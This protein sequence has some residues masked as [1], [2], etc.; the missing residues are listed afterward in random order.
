MFA[1]DD[2]DSTTKSTATIILPFRNLLRTTTSIQPSCWVPVSRYKSME[3]IVCGT[4]KWTL[5]KRRK[6]KIGNLTPYTYDIQKKNKP[7]SL[8]NNK[9]TNNCWFGQNLRP[10][11]STNQRK[12]EI[13]RCIYLIPLLPPIYLELF[14]RSKPFFF[15][16][17]YNKAG[18]ED[19]TSS[20]MKRIN[21]FY[22]STT[23]SN[24]ILYTSN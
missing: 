24:K 10:H 12:E 5:A 23:L 15:T 17:A 19:K 2:S 20:A 4:S 9:D 6:M 11:L 14:S 7:T 18:A 8:S 16:W 13:Q 1:C 22:T 21:A 3:T